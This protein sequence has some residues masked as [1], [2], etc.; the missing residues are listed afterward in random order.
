MV[1]VH[2]VGNNI[3]CILQ[4]TKVKR[5]PEVPQSVSGRVRTAAQKDGSRRICLATLL[6]QAEI[7]LAGQKGKTEP[8]TRPQRVALSLLLLW[9]G[10]CR[11][12]PQEAK[13]CAYLLTA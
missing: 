2:E 13:T 7:T 9:E 3:T 10:A 5:S 11:L 4:A 1:T 8:T 12:S 6:T